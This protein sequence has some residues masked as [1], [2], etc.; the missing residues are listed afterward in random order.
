MPA[1]ITQL[2]FQILS[3]IQSH[4]QCAFADWF[5]PWFTALGNGG[6]LWLLLAAWL[7]CRHSTR[8][9]G[10]QVLVGLLVGFLLVNLLLKPLVAR[11]RPCWLVD[12]SLLITRP[13]DF[14]FPSGH[15][16]SAFIV[17]FSLIA[18]WKKAGVAAL[19]VAF[20]MAFSRLYLYV[21]FPSDILASVLIAALVSAGV[22]WLSAAFQ[23]R[24]R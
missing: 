20:L 7:L 14:S 15:T 18:K 9:Q 5:F 11:P 10:V 3:F 22:R 21:H 17:A 24:F 12:F 19:A 16:A 23:K 13:A 6:F 8:R 1:I 2:D 4:L